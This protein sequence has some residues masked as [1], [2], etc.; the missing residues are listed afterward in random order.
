MYRAESVIGDVLNA[1]DQ[2]MGGAFCRAYQSLG[3]AP[4]KVTATRQSLELEY[5]MSPE[6]AASIVGAAT[7]ALFQMQLETTHGPDGLPPQTGPIF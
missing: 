3:A 5:Q 6:M 4:T 1:S 2:R 7:L